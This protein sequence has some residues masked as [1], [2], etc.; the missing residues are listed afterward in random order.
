MRTYD[1]LTEALND[2]KERGYTE[3]FSLR[4]YCLEC[5]A[6]EIEI[7][8]ENFVVDEFYRFEGM[9]NPDDNSVLFAITS[10]DGLKGTLVDAYGVYAENLSPEMSTSLHLKY[11]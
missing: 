9:T 3:D 6:K 7:H 10:S 4:P 2:L 11:A 1:T 8:P 5:K